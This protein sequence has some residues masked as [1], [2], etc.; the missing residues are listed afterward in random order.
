MRGENVSPA[1]R[2]WDIHC[3]FQGVNGSPSV[4]AS[5]PERLRRT[6]CSLDQLAGSGS[7]KVGSRSSTI[8]R[9]IE[10]RF[11]ARIDEHSARPVGLPSV[12]GMRSEYQ[13]LRVGMSAV[14]DAPSIAFAAT[15]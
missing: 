6:T 14:S 1:S 8:V 4:C 13:R 15:A 11:E 9:E 10:T 3:L 2:F 7:D 12:T 5:G